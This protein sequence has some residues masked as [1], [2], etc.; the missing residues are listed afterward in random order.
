MLKSL[1]FLAGLASI[2]AAL[3]TEVQEVHVRQSAPTAT[4]KNGTVIGTSSNGID[5]F[6]GIPF[7]QP[8]VG[9]LRLRPPQSLTQGFSGGS[10][11]ASKS[12]ASC[13][14]FA[15]QVDNLDL[16]DLTN[17]VVGDIVGELLQNPIVQLASNQKE[18][19]LTI[20]VQR[21]AGTT[22]SSNLPVIFWI[23]GGG[24]EAGSWV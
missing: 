1:T 23:Y 21:P 15:F 16:S 20:T 10:F 7:A 6:S 22:A 18:D 12:A 14:Q 5:S 9:N 19:C 8:P 13:P 17:S 24:F 4:T 2:A 3:P 11:D